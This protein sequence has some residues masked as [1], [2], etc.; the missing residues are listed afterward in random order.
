MKARLQVGKPGRYCVGEQGNYG[1][2]SSQEQ[3]G[4]CKDGGN[5]G[6]PICQVSMGDK[7]QNYQDDDDRKDDASGGCRPAEEN[8]AAEG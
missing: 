6:H 3:R 1:R 4:P 2:N 5:L 7:R 8:L